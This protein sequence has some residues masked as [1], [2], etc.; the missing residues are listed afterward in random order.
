A[1]AHDAYRAARAHYD[2]LVA[3]E[4]GE[5]EI[6]A[7]ADAAAEAGL[8]YDAAREAAL[9]TVITPEE[10]LEVLQLS[11]RHV[12][13]RDEQTR[14]LVQLPSAFDRAWEVLYDR[15][16]RAGTPDESG[17][18]PLQ[19]QLSQ[20]REAYET[21]HAN[22]RTLDDP[23]DLK[24]L[25]QGA[26]VL[27]F[28]I[29]AN[30]NEH[31][32][33]GELRRTLRERGPRNARTTDAAWYQI[34]R[35]EDWVNTAQDLRRMQDSPAEY[36]RTHAG[37]YVVEEYNGEYWMLLWDVRGKR[38]TAFEGDWQLAS[39]RQDQDPQSGQPAIGFRMDARG[40]QLLGELTGEHVGE[41][42]AV[43]LDD[44]VYK[45]GRASCRG[46]V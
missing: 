27:Q 10:V 13:K 24:R 1:E 20:V 36:F 30:P 37:G 29:G 19:R 23:S 28:R 3:Q 14:E 8:A 2:D 4:A 5:A 43:L 7:A 42:M 39:A 41:S 40:A 9:A 38:L 22:R 46:G 16:G 44:Q 6:D 18:T 17:E 34:N 21:Y 45:S 25:L 31:P 11:R 26:G 32:Q 15:A 12:E 33:E 35:I